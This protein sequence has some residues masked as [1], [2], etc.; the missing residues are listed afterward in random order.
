MRDNMVNAG[1]HDPVPFRSQGA[2]LGYRIVEGGAGLERLW[3]GFE[4]RA[5]HTP[6]QR[7]DWAAAFHA[8]HA[9]DGGRLLGVVLGAGEV[10]L[11]LRLRRGAAGTVAEIPG[12]KHANFQHPLVL[13]GARVDGAA[14]RRALAEAGRALGLDAVAFRNMPALW[15]GTPNPL[16]PPGAGR[17][18]SDA[19]TLGLDGLPETVVQGAFGRETRRKLRRKMRMLWELGP[20]DFAQASRTIE[21]EEI[22]D[23]FFVQKAARMRELGLPDAFAA[24]ETRDF[25]RRA[26][27]AGLPEGRPAVELYALR[28][29]DRILATF[30]GAATADRLCGMFNSHDPDPGLARCSPGE[31]LLWCLVRQQCERGRRWFDL[32][33]G[34]AAYK[35]QLCDGVEALYEAVLPL[36]ARGAVY[37]GAASAVVALK[38]AVKRSPA[39]WRVASALRRARRAA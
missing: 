20:L 38:R 24:P 37:A 27:T 16:L 14:A 31:V 39:A 13:R 23:A 29:G 35:A 32:G 22:L 34:E 4:A 17:G 3:R 11:P 26:C 25:L 2:A 5:V 7:Y 28:A 33:V 15:D 1:R 18:A 10:L 19:Y 21:A 36:S 9:S 30:G 12:G 8:A 6:Y